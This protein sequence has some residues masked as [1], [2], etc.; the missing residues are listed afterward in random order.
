M[1]SPHFTMIGMTQPTTSNCRP[2]YNLI[3]SSV[4]ESLQH[5]LL[6]ARRATS[7]QELLS[8]RLEPRRTPPVQTDCAPTSAARSHSVADTPLTAAR[9]AAVISSPNLGVLAVA[10]A[11]PGLRRGHVIYSGVFAVAGVPGAGIRWLW[12]SFGVLDHLC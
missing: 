4:D 8:P 6:M 1:N 7:G 5:P 12:P 2:R 11:G 9:S 3:L 10:A